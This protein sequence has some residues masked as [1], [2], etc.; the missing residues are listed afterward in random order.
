MRKMKIRDSLYD[1]ITYPDF[2]RG[3][4]VY[5][6]YWESVA[7]I[8]DDGYVYPIRNPQYDNRPGLYPLGLGMDWFKGPMS[9]Y[10][11][12]EYSTANIIDFNDAKSFRDV[13]EMQNRL[14]QE[15]RSILTTINQLTI[16]TIQDNDEPAM[17][18]LKEAIIAK[19][20]DLDSYD[21]RFGE[22]NFPN[23]KRLLKKESI[24]LKKL[25]AYC[26]ALDI[27]ATLTLSDLNPDV[28]NPMG[29]DIVY[30]LNHDYDHETSME[31][32]EDEQ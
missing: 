29:K 24:S 1:V 21:Y 8:G 9:T 31:E 13:I 16:P 11:M 20:I 14:N 19:H 2:T 32:G 15:E 3:R 7:I 4:D 18:A 10:E 5:M 6:K 28:P 27:N 22:S 17:V 30:S 12:R 26:N 25:I 23:D